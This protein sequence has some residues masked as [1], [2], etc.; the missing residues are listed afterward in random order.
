MCNTKM[1]LE[2]LSSFIDLPHAYNDI[3][4]NGLVNHSQAVVPGSLFVALKGCRTDGS[5]FLDEAIR[6]G[7]AAALVEP[8][9]NG[10]AGFPV[11]PVEHLRR[12]QG[13]IAAFIHGYPSRKLRVIGVTGTNGK[14]T[15]AH[16]IHH[17]L[18]SANIPAGLI[19]TVLTNDGRETRPASHTT[20]DSIELQA[21]LRRM[22]ENG[23]KTVVM[24]VSSHALALERVA[25]LEFD[26]AI[27][28]NITHDHFDFHNDHQA[29]MA[30][31]SLLFTHLHEGEKDGK[32][33]V[34]NADDPSF[35]EIFRQCRTSISTYGLSPKCDARIHWI[36]SQGCKTL[37]NVGLWNI[38]YSFA[39]FLP[40]IFNIYNI[41]AAVTV[42]SREG[43]AISDISK[44]VQSFPGVPGRYQEINCGQPFR[45]MVDFA[46]NPAAL[47][48]ILKMA[49]EQTKGRIILAFGCEGKKDRTKRPLMGRTAVLYADLPIL[50]S[51]NLYDED[52]NQILRD[53]R[54][55]LSPVECSKLLVIPDRR[56]ALE[57][58]IQAAQAGDF[59]IIAGKGH[60]QFLIKGSEKIPFNDA[61]VLAEIL[62][63][64]GY[65]INRSRV[66][67]FS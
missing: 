25:G 17:I 6:R 62:A 56:V 49:A 16:L 26:V 44:A 7:A 67:T 43:V 60:E 24:E 29:Y 36:K 46:H 54:S 27:L 34:L 14:T 38:A 11:I 33:A 20:P 53:V 59:V 8:G 51:D 66:L 57:W 2:D 55:G 63:A 58:A 5:L 64:Q 10:P 21:M 47:E 35:K 23:V 9:F 22:V 12:T 32:Y 45:V 40:G 19:G 1:R 31:K 30:A 50:T 65:P 18:C 61:D 28:T 42:A 3:Y 37:L 13:E 15:V 41:L 39:T 48:N 52:P 4:F